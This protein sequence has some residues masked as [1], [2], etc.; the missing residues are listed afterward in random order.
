M[1]RKKKFH[2]QNQETTHLMIH[3]ILTSKT[4]I[5]TRNTVDI[6]WVE[7]LKS[8]IIQVVHVMSP[9]SKS[10]FKL[11]IKKKI[12][13]N[14]Q[15]DK[16]IRAYIRLKIMKQKPI[17]RPKIQTLIVYVI[18]EY[19]THLVLVYKKSR[20]PSNTTLSCPGIWKNSEHD[21]A[22]NNNNSYSDL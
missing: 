7:N 13:I 21:T 11:V 22:G 12:E 19:H 1:Q 3:W 15:N 9:I 20:R 4:T 18:M 14:K 16:W 8:E 2:L 6:N 10:S 17:D 5:P